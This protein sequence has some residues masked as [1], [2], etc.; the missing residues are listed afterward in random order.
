[1]GRPTGRRQIAQPTGPQAG[2]GPPDAPAPPPTRAAAGRDI[3]RDTSALPQPGQRTSAS[4]DARRTSS[5][6]TFPHGPQ[7]YS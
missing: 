2:A 1:M 3:W 4:S 7:A 6:K 5:S